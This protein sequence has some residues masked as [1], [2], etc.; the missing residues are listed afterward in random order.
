MVVDIIAEMRQAI[1][2]ASE[3]YPSKRAIQSVFDVLTLPAQFDS[4]MIT[5]S[6]GNN[7]IVY[8]ERKCKLI[9]LWELLTGDL[10]SVYNFRV[11]LNK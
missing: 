4:M 2:R 8:C 9:L 5:G 6:D 11:V 7:Y 10:T 3:L 1:K